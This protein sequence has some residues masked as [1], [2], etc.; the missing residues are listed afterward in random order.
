MW[1]LKKKNDHRRE[2]NWKEAFNSQQVT[3]DLPPQSELQDQMEMIRFEKEELQV[4]K[5]L[6]PIVEENIDM[7]VSTF[8]NTILEV[9][10]LKNIIDQHSSIDR[11]RDTLRGHMIEMFS[12]KI[13]EQYVQKRLRVARVHVRIGLEPKWY[14]GAF[15]NLQS[16]LLDLVNDH[17]SNR[18]ERYLANKAISKILNF[19]QQLVL[20]E[21]EKENLRLR[22][23]QYEE[24]KEEIKG[25]IS[26]TSKELVLL[27]ERTNE[28][29]QQVTENVN[30]VNQ[31]IRDSSQLSEETQNL[32]NSGQRLVE[33]L[34]TV[35]N[36]VSI[37][38][39]EI[40]Q[41]IEKLVHS[42][43]EIRKVI[44]LVQHIADQTNL[45]A[46]NASIEAARAGEYG[47]G[48]AV[49]AEEVRKLAEE[50]RNSVR[51]ITELI[52]KSTE[53]TSEVTESI[54]SVQKNVEAGQRSSAETRS[55]FNEILNSMNQ[56]MIRINQVE[57]DVQKLTQVMEGIRQGTT[58]VADTAESLDRLATNI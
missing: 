34:A 53:M 14:M 27:T 54:A 45:L 5:A 37:K 30:E 49:V 28:S 35:M 33:E 56:S 25:E 48:F 55:T 50:S 19:E 51:D 11:L 15:Q 3:I 29:V 21:Y 12:G 32:A 26:A 17:L 7:I 8:Y 38:G 39:E 4:I 41:V 20:E 2:S 18:E 47:R 22:E 9:P 46:L 23:E 6:Q 1:L 42:S 40:Q 13:D 24:V 57:N 16:A 10:H 52:E 44:S 43:T 31:A 58:Q 36:S